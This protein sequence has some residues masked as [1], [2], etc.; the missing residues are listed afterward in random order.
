MP[1]KQNLIIR[2]KKLVKYGF[3]VEY[4]AGVYAHKG[5]AGLKNIEDIV[6]KYK[7]ERSKVKK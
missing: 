1:R 5:E 4:S 2:F 7:K 3:P 6:E